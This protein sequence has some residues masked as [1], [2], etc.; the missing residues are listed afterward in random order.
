[1]CYFR[2]TQVIKDLVLYNDPA[3]CKVLFIPPYVSNII[4]IYN[5]VY[6]VHTC[7]NIK[8]ISYT[9]LN[10]VYAL[11]TRSIRGKIGFLYYKNVNKRINI[12]YVGV[13]EN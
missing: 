12:K 9:E 13:I 3:V 10:T 8:E 6:L 5:I 7:R 11:N 4:I 2:N 1:M